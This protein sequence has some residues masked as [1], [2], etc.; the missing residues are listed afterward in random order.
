MSE[1]AS[2][3]HHHHN[4]PSLSSQCRKREIIAFSLL[5]LLGLAFRIVALVNINYKSIM[6]ISH[7]GHVLHEFN[8]GVTQFKTNIEDF[9]HSH[10]YS[11]MCIVTAGSLVMPLTRYWATVWF[12]FGKNFTSSRRV[13]VITVLD[14]LGKL[15]MAEF[16]GVMINTIFF[17][18]D[19][20][21]VGLHAAMR[22]SFFTA[23]HLGNFSNIVATHLMH[24]LM[25][26]TLPP[27][28]RFRAVKM[29]G[30][31]YVCSLVSVAC[32]IHLLVWKVDIMHFTLTG[33][34]GKAFQ[35]EKAF[36]LMTFFN[37]FPDSV[38]HGEAGWADFSASFFLFLCVI[39]PVA[40]TVAWL[41][42]LF[43][44]V[45]PI[46]QARIAQ[47]IPF[48]SSWVGTE[49]F[50][51]VA[52]SNVYENGLVADFLFSDKAPEL[53]G[54]LERRVG[55]SCAG[56]DG[57]FRPGMIS[58]I[59]LCMCFHFMRFA[60]RRHLYELDEEDE[61]DCGSEYEELEDDVENNRRLADTPNS[62][63][64]RLL[65]QFEEN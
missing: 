24:G 43:L 39:M 4:A 31:M 7:N 41:V 9:Y 50:T 64:N 14:V 23:F 55:E 10:A 44:P 28:H 18:I 48:A 53:C 57:E 25:Y 22:I 52:I 29:T 21:L 16:Y 15:M 17:K 58:M 6:G 37:D 56:V 32:W 20:N 30:G 63:T 38:Q 36:G 11:T 65:N 26:M 61:D 34:V 5:L 49:V 54:A 59:L 13:L 1:P 2:S 40:V 45:G 19:L 46:M 47:V 33:L 35:K 12:F 51:L 62:P 42:A 60:S 8:M 27:I 3:H